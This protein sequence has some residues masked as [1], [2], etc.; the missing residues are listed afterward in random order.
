MTPKIFSNSLTSVPL[1]DNLP[2]ET[3][4]NL[5]PGCR[6]GCWSG[7]LSFLH[8]VFPTNPFNHTRDVGPPVP[9]N[10]DGG[11]PSGPPPTKQS[12]C[13]LSVKIVG[14]LSDEGSQVSLRR[15]TDTSLV[16]EERP[17]SVRVSL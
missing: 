17:V 4:F 2:K 12:S 3:F 10:T 11:E 15:V 7:V 14:T 1:L 13:S 9:T 16:T 8:E 5:Y 6:E